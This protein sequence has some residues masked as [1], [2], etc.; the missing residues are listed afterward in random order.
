DLG[1]MALDLINDGTSV[2]QNV[3]NWYAYNAQELFLPANGGSFT[4]NLG[5]TQDD[6]THI[7]SLPMRGDLLIDLGAVGNLT[8]VVTGTGA[9]IV[10]ATADQIDVRLAGTGQQDVTLRM[11][12]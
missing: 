5:T 1:G 11:L 2:I 7:A 10:S 8:P 4:I 12:L 9:A 3:T 6:V